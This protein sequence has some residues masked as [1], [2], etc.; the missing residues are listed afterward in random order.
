[1]ESSNI[2]L[3]FYLHESLSDIK[4]HDDEFSSNVDESNYNSSNKNSDTSSLESD[5]NNSKKNK[6]I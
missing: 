6:G 4:S 5:S 2:D 1:M 3:N